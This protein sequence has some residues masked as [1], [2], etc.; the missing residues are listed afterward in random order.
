MNM[1]VNSHRFGSV[2]ATS[3]ANAGGT[4]NRTASI[5]L[6]SVSITTGGGSVTTL[7]DGALAN[8]YYWANATG[9]GTGWLLFD[10]GSGVSK[11]IDEF[12]WNQGNTNSHGTWRFEGSNDNSSWTQCGSDFT[13]V[14]N[15]TGTTFSVPNTTAYRY[16][17]LRHM[18]GARSNIPYLREIEFKI[19]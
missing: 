7:I 1:I 19:A 14:D 16:Y 2:V 17:R 12:K 10:F 5:T 4:G 11:V 13:L 8:G 3:Y 15:T 18:S 6:T 9:N